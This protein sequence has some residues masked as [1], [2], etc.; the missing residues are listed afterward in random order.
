MKKL[1]IISF[2]ILTILIAGCSFRYSSDDCP[3]GLC[4]DDP[5]EPKPDFNET[6]ITLPPIIVPP[7]NETNTTLNQTT[8]YTTNLTTNT[9]NLSSE[10]YQYSSG[11]RNNNNNE[12]EKVEEQKTT[13]EEKEDL[14]ALHKNLIAASNEEKLFPNEQTTDNNNQEATQPRTTNNNDETDVNLDSKSDKKDESN[15]FANTWKKIVE[16]V[17]SVF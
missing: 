2:I 7:I 10:Q 6:N 9:S 5:I 4:D 14:D 11:K 16:I 15:F 13:Q 8:N 12:D 1:F 3:A 17:E